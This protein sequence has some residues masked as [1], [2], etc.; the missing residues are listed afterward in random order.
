MACI[1]VVKDVPR[2]VKNLG[3]LIN[4]AGEVGVSDVEV[5]GVKLT[6]H[7]YNGDQHFSDWADPSVLADWLRNRRSFVGVPI[8]YNGVDGVIGKHFPQFVRAS[9]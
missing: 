3:Y 7:Y 2:K 1:E 4:K 8:R 6:V 9:V 5:E